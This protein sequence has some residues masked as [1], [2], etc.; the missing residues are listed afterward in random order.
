MAQIDDAEPIAFGIFQYDEVGVRWVAIPVDPAGA[1]RHKPRSLRLLFAGVGGM[2]SGGVWLT[3]RAI[4][5]PASP[6]G[7]STLAQ[8]P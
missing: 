7:T 6:G 3:W 5:A 1:K 4:A 8:P 2:Q